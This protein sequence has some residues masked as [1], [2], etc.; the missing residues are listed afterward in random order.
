MSRP[1]PPNSRLAAGLLALSLGGVL[2]GC[3]DRDVVAK[4]GRTRV[5]LGELDAFV[6]GAGGS[7][8][9]DRKAALDALVAR[10][11]LA[12]AGRRADVEDEPAVKARLAA[13][14]REILAMAYLERE[15]A[16]ATREDVLRARYQA[17]REKLGR[18]RVHVAH[19][20]VQPRDGVPDPRGEARA[21]ATKLY[22]RIVGGEAFE[23]VAKDASDDRLSAARGGDLGPILEGQ[24]D[25]GFFQQAS[26]LAPGEISRPFETPFGFQIVK[27]L[28]SQTVVTPTFEEARGR[29]EAEA[30]REAEGRLVERLRADLSVELHPDRIQRGTNPSPEGK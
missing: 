11:L 14:R 16:A 22:G 8:A 30:R 2:A 17:G 3:G 21:R 4:V 13:S 19:I 29:L 28:E 25:A 18:R 26:A 20:A 24:T 15:L 7:L 9:T 5:T 23:A 27:A 12:E 1:R 10:A 6:A